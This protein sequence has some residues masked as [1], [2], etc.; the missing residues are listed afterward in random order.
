MS[1]CAG[2][3]HHQMEPTWGGKSDSAGSLRANCAHALVGCDGLGNQ[4]LLTLLLT[5]L[6][7][8]DKS[9]RVEAVRALAQLGESAVP[10]L[11]LRALL[12][13]EDSEEMSAACFGALL[14]IEQETAVPFVAGFLDAEDECAAEAAFALAETHSRGHLPRFLSSEKGGTGPDPWFASVLLSAIALTRI[15]EAINYLIVLIESD[16]R[17]APSAIEALGRIAPSAEL[18]ARVEQAIEQAD[19][20]RLR[21]AFRQHLPEPPTHE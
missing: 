2:L 13:G 20:P 21:E 16:T 19:G 11:R 17:E 6:V 14:A 7:D 9:V 8:K 4:D 3:N 12:P 18:R 15:P 5:P 1:F 10:L